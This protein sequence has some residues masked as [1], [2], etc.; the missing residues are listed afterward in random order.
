M[1]TI[2]DK[3]IELSEDDAYSMIL[4]KIGRGIDENIPYYKTFFSMVNFYK[5][6]D[7]NIR[8]FFDMRSNEVYF[9]PYNKVIKK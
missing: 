5:L 7:C 4:D 2:E 8:Y 3:L 6:Q 1:K 9:I